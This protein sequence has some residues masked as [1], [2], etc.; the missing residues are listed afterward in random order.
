MSHSS[1]SSTQV[2]DRDKVL[3]AYCETMKKKPPTSRLFFFDYDGTLAPIVPNPPDA[4]PS[5]KVKE[6]LSKLCKVDG[7]YVYIISGRDRKDLEDWLGDLDVGF[8]AEHGCFLKLLQKESSHTASTSSEDEPNGAHEKNEWIDI[9]KEKGMDVSWVPNVLSVMK[10]FCS[11]CPGSAIERKTYALVW[12]YRN[13]QSSSNPEGLAV[14]LAD[15]LNSIDTG[16]FNVINGKK[17]VEVRPSG[18]NKGTIVKEL[19]SRHCHDN[20]E[21]VLCMGD[22]TTDEDMFQQLSKEKGVPNLFTVR[23]GEESTSASSCLERQDEVIQV[24]EMLATSECT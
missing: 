24:L 20:L 6:I 21:F 7:N 1:S 17:N 10:E 8:S 9:P 18:I 23:V 13:A 2:L 12:H 5:P 15:S 14:K 16:H 22:D 11:Q 3:H 19:L 4:K